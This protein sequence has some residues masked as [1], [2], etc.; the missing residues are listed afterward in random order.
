MRTVNTAPVV[1]AFDGDEA[2]YVEGAA[3]VLLD[4]G[5]NALLTDDSFDLFEDGTLVVTMTQN[6][7][8]G[9]DV[10]GIAQTGVVSLSDGYAESSVVSVS[11]VPIGKFAASS[12][13]ANGEPLTIVFN[14]DANAANIQALIRAL[15]YENSN[16][17]VPSTLH[18]TVHV[19]LT[20][21]DGGATT[22]NIGVDVVGLADA[23]VAGTDGLFLSRGAK[24]TFDLSILLENDTSQAGLSLSITGIGPADTGSVSMDGNGHFTLNAPASG[25]SDS[26]TYILSNGDAT[27]RGLVNATLL[28]TT[29]RNDT[30]SVPTAT[31]EFSY[32]DG[33]QGN[34][35]ITG[36]DGTDTLLGSKGADKLLGGNGLDTLSGGAQNDR[37][38][39]GAGNDRLT[40][41]AGAD[42]FIFDTALDAA[43]NVDQ[44]D[45]FKAA[46]EFRLSTA[47]FSEAGPAGRLLLTAFVSNTTGDAGDASDRIVYNEATGELHYDFD[48]NGAG[49]S[50][51]FAVIDAN[52]NL[53]KSD[54]VIFEF[55]KQNGHPLSAN[56]RRF[57]GRAR[58]TGGTIRAGGLCP[59]QSRF[60][61]A[62]LTHP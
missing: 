53:N 51:L 32:I 31:D 41:G 33:K 61:A 62:A 35:T 34:D 5:S 52:L 7:V 15:T 16:A 36:G 48:G 12:S 50:I 38:S 13:G 60:L 57:P 9:E 17:A 54:F 40:G 45:D 22:A 18:R 29:K 21:G 10:L 19:A 2:T 56:G 6:P 25:D 47:I 1:A 37:L 49:A 43:N 44:I 11:G 59:R 58:M 14:D 55:A 46:D 26:F 42:K 28:A 3:A 8:P 24:A 27:T 23:P 4:Q 39:G 20:D 30:V